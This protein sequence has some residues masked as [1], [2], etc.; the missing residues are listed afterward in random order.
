MSTYDVI[1]RGGMVVTR[2][3][4][5]CADI[6]VAEGRIVEVADEIAGTAAQEIDAGGL[7]V[8]PGVIDA[9]VHFNEPGRSEWEG[10]ATGTR[11]L[12]AGGAT[13][14]FDMPLN[15]HP[16][17]VDG[18]SF[19]AKVAAARASALVDFGLWG[20]IVPGNVDRLDEL[21]DRGVVGFKAFMSASGIE[22]FAAVDDLTLYEGISRAAR[23]GCLVAVHAEND[24]ITS[25]LARRAVAEGRTE[26]RD[27][28]GSRPVVAELEAISRAILFA[29]ETGCT[30][31]IVH[32]SCGRGVEL[33]AQAQARGVDVSCETC[34]HYLVLTE[35]DVERLG[36]LAKCAPPLRSRAEQDALWRHID[37]G[38]LP[39]V[40]SDHSPAPAELKSDA[41]FFKVWGGISGCQSLL[42][43]LLTAGYE[44]RE[45]PPSLIAALTSTY[46]AE[47]FAL[48]AKGGIRVGVDADL[49]LVDVD[50]HA[51]LRAEDLHYRHRH[52]PYVGMMLRGRVVRTL[53]RG[54]TVYADGAF[55]AEP[56]GQLIRPA[57]GAELA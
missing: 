10:F 13:A 15:A 8:F 47:R 51:E 42:A 31:H 6:G 36:A 20:G 55:A 19:D 34:P 25:G 18:A 16:P 49:A 27:Y 26:I 7:H 46:I 5:H 44:E 50:A 32:V 24:A 45:V 9:H 28:L 48:P 1:V 23:L 33:V 11:A 56:V 29:E 37:D 52:S 17:T 41:N 2:S 43:L 12:A 38:T 57:R 54:M 22:D 3:D 14:C 21:A 30:L 53:V 4:A 39:M 40:V 35:E